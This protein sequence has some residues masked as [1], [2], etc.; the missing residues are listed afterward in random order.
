MKA[1]ARKTVGIDD[2]AAYV[3]HLY[4]PIATL[5]E[6]RDL[7]YEKLNKGL[8]LEAMAIADAREDAA[9]MMANAVRELIDKNHLDPRSIG[10]LYLGTESALDGAKPTATYAL[11]MLEAYY[12]PEYGPDCFLNCDV[13]DL[14]FACIGAVDALQN[15]LDWVNGG[16]NRL[17]IVVASDN[18][19]YEMGSGGEYTQGAGAVALLVKQQPRLLAIDPTWGVATRPV[20]DFFKPLRKVKRGDLIAEVLQ[21]A[22]RNHVDIDALIE[23]LDATIAVDGVIDSNVR[24]LA[25]HRETP[26]FD[27]P[28]SNLC[29]QNRIR[30]ALDHYRR[31]V[32]SEKEEPVATAWDRLAFHLPYAF[33][34]RRMFGEIFWQEASL[35]GQREALTAQIGMEAPRKADFTDEVEYQKALVKF[36]RAVTKT[37]SYRQ[38]VR[39]RIAKGERA[40]SLVGNVYTGSLF[41]S[42]MS[43]LET[44][45]TDGDLEAGATLGCFAYGSGSKSKVFTTRLQPQWR[46]VVAGFGLFGRLSARQ[47]IDYPTYE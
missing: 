21:L 6:A 5:A 22:N 43:T 37:D 17:G 36:W 26:V 35:T 28:Y 40:S 1:Q 7:E 10:R 2:M 32:G 38:F 30:E 11:E 25:I 18:A 27:G 45:L 33:Q 46:E 47:V 34:A 19:K 20:Y 3:P 31:Q 9:T 14:T 8:G 15:T 4:L 23:R 29:Y 16:E 12:T 24:E 39:E 42:M 44:D 13:V 41:L